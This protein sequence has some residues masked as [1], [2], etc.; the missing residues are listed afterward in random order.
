M[1]III[2]AIA[3]FASWAWCK[4]EIYIAF[5]TRW[6]YGYAV[7]I[8]TFHCYNI[9]ISS[10]SMPC[11]VGDSGLNLSYSLCMAAESTARGTYSLSKGS[12]SSS[13]TILEFIR[14]SIILFNSEEVSKSHTLF[15]QSSCVIV[16][17]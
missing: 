9:F 5:F 14:E 4:V 7:F 15:L 13:A 1:P 16:L 11:P 17:L 3:T 2:L 6:A 8:D 12:F 10:F